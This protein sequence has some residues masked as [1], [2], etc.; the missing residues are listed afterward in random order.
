[1]SSPPQKPEAEADKTDAQSVEPG[2]SYTKSTNG[3]TSSATTSN[4]NPLGKGNKGQQRL[5]VPLGHS[6]RDSSDTLSDVS[7]DSADDENE[8]RTGRLLLT[9]P[10]TRVASRAPAPPRTWRGKWDAFWLRNKGVALVLSSQLF[11][12]LMSVTTRLLETDGS[13]GKGMHPFQVC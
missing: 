8:R 2:D 9:T 6:F 5:D 13:H 11:G 12:A 10:G 7:T 4:G 3:V 1:M